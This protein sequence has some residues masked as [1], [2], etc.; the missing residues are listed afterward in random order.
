MIRT[1]VRVPSCDYYLRA[2]FISPIVRLLF[3]GG[4]DIRC[5]CT[6][7]NSHILNQKSSEN[8]YPTLL[9]CD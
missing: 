5:V 8:I 1:R 3:E 7:S 2:A 4:E 6:L 9:C